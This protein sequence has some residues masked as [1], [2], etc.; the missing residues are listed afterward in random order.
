MWLPRIHYSK[1]ALYISGKAPFSLFSVTRF[2]WMCQLSN[3]HRVMVCGWWSMTLALVRSSGWPVSKVCSVR[4]DAATSPF[5]RACWC[6]ASWC[7]R[8]GPVCPMYTLGHLLHGMEYTTPFCW[9]SGTV[10][11]G[12]TSMWRRVP[13]GRKTTLMS[14]C[15]RIR[16]TASERPFHSPPRFWK[17]Y[18]DDTC[19]VV[20]E[21]WLSPSTATWTVLSH[22]YNS[23]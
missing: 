1:S 9:S 2:F 22:I 14:S 17:C 19:P 8:V 7:L 21:I 16:L 18:V 12:C 3:R 20:P 13:S 6:S 23:R 11:L 10:F 15:V 4:A 5:F